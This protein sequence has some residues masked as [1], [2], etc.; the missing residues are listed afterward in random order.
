MAAVDKQRTQVRASR[1][2]LFA[3][4]TKKEKALYDLSRE[5]DDASRENLQLE[6]EIR[7]L[8]RVR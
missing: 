4:Q 6:R 2:A 7:R 1:E 3:E 5:L 8:E